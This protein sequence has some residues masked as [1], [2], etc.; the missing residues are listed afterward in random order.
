MA[1]PEATQKEVGIQLQGCVGSFLWHLL[2]LLVRDTA[3]YLNRVL[4]MAG[5]I[6]GALYVETGVLR[7]KNW[8]GWSEMRH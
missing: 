2:F 8:V 6:P 4:S 3:H 5:T 1:P 7:E